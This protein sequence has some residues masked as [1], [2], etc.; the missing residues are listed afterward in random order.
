MAPTCP[1]LCPRK[2]D[3]DCYPVTSGPATRNLIERQNAA[4]IGHTS[5]SVVAEEEARL[6]ALFTRGVPQ[7]GPGGGG[8]PLRLHVAGDVQTEVEARR[9]GGAIQRYRQR[10]GGVGWL[11][12]HAWRGIRRE[13][14][15]PSISSLASVDSV[16]EIEEARNMGYASALTV[17]EFPAIRPYALPGLPWRFVPCPHEV[18][19]QALDARH[20]QTGM[21]AAAYE[22]ARRTLPTCVSCQ[23]CLDADRL[24]GGRKVIVFAEH[25]PRQARAA[26]A[27]ARRAD[28]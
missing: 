10:G 27:R 19:K 17:P 28:R 2:A 9:L 13:A 20:A 3:G 15:G 6:D 8:R 23:L 18:K 1:D 26:R 14:F 25:G 5:T 24:F 21:S 11:Y 22:T 4:S 16:E 12:S 7:D